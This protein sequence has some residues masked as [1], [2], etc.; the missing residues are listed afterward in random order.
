MG[1]RPQ[2]A[3]DLH[4]FDG[5][6]HRTR[7]DLRAEKLR[8]FN[9]VATVGGAAVAGV[10]LVQILTVISHFKP[11]HASFPAL[12]KSTVDDVRNVGALLFSNYNLAFQIIGVLVLVATIGVVILS[13][14]ESSKP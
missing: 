2:L 9:W 13:K 5:Q 8:K 14:R 10:L 11:A 6:H 12:T 1:A 4:L 7:N 3:A